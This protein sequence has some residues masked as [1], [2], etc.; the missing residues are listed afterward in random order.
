MLSTASD[1]A[2]LE[3]PLPLY[4]YGEARM[5]G[6]RLE[7]PRWQ[8]LRK[9]VYADRMKHVA[10]ADWKRYAVRV[11]AY[12]RTHPD[13]ILCLESASVVHGLPQ[14]GETR[15][16]HVYDPDRR[17]SQRYGDVRVHTSRNLRDIERVNG[18]RVTSLL[19]TVVDLT[20]VM[21]PAGALAVADAAIAPAQ[22]G[23]LRMADL[24]ARSAQFESTRGQLRLRWVA[25]H[26]DA[27]A[28]SP[29]ESISRAVMLWSGYEAPE[30]QRE[31]EYESESDRVDFHFPFCRVV[32]ESDGWGKYELDMPERAA[33]RLRQEKRRED[34]LRRHGHPVAR[35]DL[36]DAWRVRPLCDA[37]DAAGV[38]RVR[39]PEHVM[40]ATLRHRPRAVPHR[41]LDAPHE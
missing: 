30:L 12:L 20:R 2:L 11:H 4:T 6:I 13:A 37:L 16:I 39:P 21:S 25:E 23:T 17:A 14:F 8:R 35:W 18:V 32:G 5:L 28:E 24:M 41:P 36:A 7:N 22:G 26:A 15:F 38:P 40:L 10:L 34:R 1:R 9:G 19:D 29:A 3:S 31:F 27:R 33:L